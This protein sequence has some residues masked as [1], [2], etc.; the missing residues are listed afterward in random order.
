MKRFTSGSISAI[1]LAMLLIW[2]CPSAAGQSRDNAEDEA[3]ELKSLQKEQIA[4]L[5][6]RVKVLT[7]QNQ[8]GGVDF[9]QVCMAQMDLYDAKLDA[10][11]KP[12]ERIAVLEEQLKMAESAQK[13]V[14]MRFATGGAG[15]TQANVL[16]AK[17]LCLKIKIRLVRERSKQK[18]K[19]G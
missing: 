15:T 12:N 11:D 17:S 1:L 5:S 4:A 6:Q 2:T 14:E 7:R 18:A 8:V 10:T 3:S 13:L 19:A 16:S 9:D